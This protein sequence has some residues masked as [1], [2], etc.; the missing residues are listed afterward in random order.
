MSESALVIRKM[1]DVL[2][3]NGWH[4]G[5][6]FKS[7]DDIKSVADLNGWPMN[8]GWIFQ[9]RAC[10]LQGALNLIMDN[11]YYSPYE[12]EAVDSLAQSIRALYPGHVHDCPRTMWGSSCMGTDALCYIVVF[13]DDPHTTWEDITLILKDA[14]NRL[15]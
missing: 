1:R 12:L 5:S 2:V 6:L 10:C 3:R 14:E 4:Q 8:G 11:A 15:M 7:V 9:D 13:N